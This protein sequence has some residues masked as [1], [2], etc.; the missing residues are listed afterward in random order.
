VACS[1]TRYE[2][3][4]QA[5]DRLLRLPCDARL[6]YDTLLHKFFVLYDLPS[7]LAT[8]ELNALKD[9]QFIILLLERTKEQLPAKVYEEL[10]RNVRKEF[11]NCGRTLSSAAEGT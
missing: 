3:H 4:L 11:G 10:Q 9:G 6:H 1:E 5:I 8:E 2:E 7:R